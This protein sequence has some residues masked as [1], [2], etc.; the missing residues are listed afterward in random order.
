MQNE[1]MMR[2]KKSVLGKKI[3]NNWQ[4]YLLVVPAM[5]YYIIL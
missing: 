3:L 1:L 5:A 4:L 2:Q